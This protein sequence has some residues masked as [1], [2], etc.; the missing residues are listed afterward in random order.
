[1]TAP[2]ATSDWWKWVLVTYS[3]YLMWVD[4]HPR[5][6]IPFDVKAFKLDGSNQSLGSTFHRQRGTWRLL[7]IV[8]P[9]IVAVLPF[10]W[11]PGVHWQRLWMPLLGLVFFHGGYW[12][13]YFNPNL[14]RARKLDYIDP[15]HVSWAANAAWIDRYVW[16]EA[17]ERIHGPL[18]VD[19]GV[20]DVDVAAK[21]RDLYPVILRQ[22]LW[23][24]IA[25][26]VL[27]H[28]FFYFYR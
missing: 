7:A 3:L 14:S 23:A 8:V 21:S 11:A 10:Y 15:W 12:M 18:P 1:M 17:W 2:E 25:C 28:F 13:W 16:A 26:F 6:W 5:L 27:L 22:M 4:I 20:Y 24:G 19:P 9:A